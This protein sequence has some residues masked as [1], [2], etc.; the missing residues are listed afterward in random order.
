MLSGEIDFTNGAPLQDLQRLCRPPGP[1]GP[2]DQRAAHG[3]L[4]LQPRRQ[5]GGSDVT[6]KNPFKDKRVREALYRAIDIDA[7]QKRVMRGL[8][9][10]TGSLVAPAIPGYVPALD[11]RPALR[12][13]RRQEAAGRG[14]LS[15]TASPSRSICNNDGLVNEEEFCQAV[16]SMWS[17]A[18][19]KPQ[20]EHRAAQ[21]ADAQARQGRVRRHLARLGQRADDRRLQHPDPGHAQQE[22]HR[23]VFNWGGWSPPASTR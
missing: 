20:L 11:E 1:E 7:V 9:R 5:A 15:R 13:R 23:G 22:R 3:V 18:G 16:A 6:D 8:S 19:L 4:R 2:A 14:R 12:P 17:R 10:N 21:P